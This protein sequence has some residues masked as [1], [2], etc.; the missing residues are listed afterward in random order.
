MNDICTELGISR[1]Q[2]YRKVKAVLG[3]NENEYLLN[4]RMQKA[5]Y[6]L[7]NENLSIAEVS[8]KVGFASTTYFATDFKVNFSVTP[9]AFKEKR[10]RVEKQTS[11]SVKKFLK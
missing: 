11:Y 4:V 1:V 6:L 8:Y 9:K 10:S 3:N 2:L 5:K 7:M